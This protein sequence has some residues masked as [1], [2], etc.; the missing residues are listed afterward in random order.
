MDVLASV[1]PDHIHIPYKNKIKKT[2][3]TSVMIKERILDT[4]DPRKRV[5]EDTVT[6]VNIYSLQKTPPSFRHKVYYEVDTDES[7]CC[8]GDSPTETD[9]CV[10][11]LD[12]EHENEDDE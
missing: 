10:I 9:D 1:T 4:V 11:N 7:N 8:S 6:A 3:D 5:K 2:P 12:K